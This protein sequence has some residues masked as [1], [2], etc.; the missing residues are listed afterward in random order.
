[1]HSR[2]R[3]I[4]YRLVPGTIGCELGGNIDSILGVVKV[5]DNGIN[6]EKE[7]HITQTLLMRRSYNPADDYQRMIWRDKVSFLQNKLFF[8]YFLWTYTHARTPK[9]H[10]N[11]TYC[12][13]SI[14]NT[15][16]VSMNTR[17]NINDFVSI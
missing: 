17:W 6:K 15:I 14:R 5:V 13:M 2:G 3:Y 9:Q 4:I 11:I 10:N 1:M 16:K 8:F 7:T 12:I